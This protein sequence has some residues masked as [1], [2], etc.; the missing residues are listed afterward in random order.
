DST[1]VAVRY[2]PARGCRWS[3][4]RRGSPPRWR[5]GGCMQVDATADVVII[6][7]GVVGAIAAGVLGRRG[8]AVLGG[9]AR[10]AG[11]RREGGAGAGVATGRT[12]AEGGGG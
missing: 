12:R 9:G 11:R 10:P 3:V 4:S 2:I 5:W 8:L 1:C 6:G 7:G